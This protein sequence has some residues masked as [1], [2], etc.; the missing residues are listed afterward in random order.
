MIVLLLCV[1]EEVGVVVGLVESGVGLAEVGLG[2][3]GAVGQ[4]GQRPRGPR[5]HLRRRGA[6]LRGMT[7]RESLG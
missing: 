3:L 1:G 7:Q 6:Q 2:A 5:R 4:R